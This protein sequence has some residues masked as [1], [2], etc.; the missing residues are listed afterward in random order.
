MPLSFAGSS[1]LTEFDTGAD[2]YAYGVAVTTDV[3]GLNGGLMCTAHPLDDRVRLFGSV[4]GTTVSFGA[5]ETI[6]GP[7]AGE[8]FGS[9]VA[10]SGDYFNAV[11]AVGARD[12]ESDAGR[13]YVYRRTH[14]SDFALEATVTAPTGVTGFGACVDVYY[15]TVL[16]GVME[17][18]SALIVGALSGRAYVYNYNDYSWDDTPEVLTGSFHVDGDITHSVAIRG[19]DS[20]KAMAFYGSA[21][22][23][24]SRGI[25]YQ[26]NRN[27]LGRWD[28]S[29]INVGNSAFDLFGNSCAVA[30]HSQT[31]FAIVIGAPGGNYY[32][33]GH[34][35]GSGPLSLAE[36]AAPQANS[37]YGASVSIA[38]TADNYV[39]AVGAPAEDNNIGAVYVSEYTY[40]DSYGLSTENTE[41]APTDSPASFGSQ[42]AVWGGVGQAV[43]AA[44]AP[45]GTSSRVYAGVATQSEIEVTS[46][47]EWNA[48]STPLT[49][50]VRL[51]SN[52]S[53]AVAPLVKELGAYTLYGDGHTITSTTGI[54]VEFALVSKPVGGMVRDLR[55]TGAHAVTTHSVVVD[56]VNLSIFGHFHQVSVSSGSLADEA[57]GIFGKSFGHRAFPSIVSECSS[58]LDQ[59]AGAVNAGGLI[60]P[61]SV[62]VR[63]T[64][65]AYSG[66]L[67]DGESGGIAATLGINASDQVDLNARSYMQF[68][69]SNQETLTFGSSN[70]MGGLVG[71]LGNGVLNACANYGAVDATVAG[72]LVAE[73]VTDGSSQFAN[74]YMIT[75]CYDAKANGTRPMVGRITGSSDGSAAYLGIRDSYSF[76]QFA[77]G[78]MTEPSVG[79]VS[80]FLSLRVANVHVHN[81]DAIP[82]Y[83]DTQPASVVIDVSSS[84]GAFVITGAGA[85]LTDGG[86]G[87]IDPAFST[88][89]WCKAVSNPPLLR[90]FA[91]ERVGGAATDQIFAG[92]AEGQ[93]PVSLRLVRVANVASESDW[94]SLAWYDVVRL[95][96]NITFTADPSKIVFL[97]KL[98][99]DGRGYTVTHDYADFE[100]FVRLSGG[101]ASNVFIEASG[102]T[103]LTEHGF[104]TPGPGGLVARGAVVNVHAS[105]GAIADDG[106][107]IVGAEFGDSALTSTLRFCTY[108]GVC[109][110]FAGGAITG[111]DPKYLTLESCYAVPSDGGGI[112]TRLV[113]AK[114]NGDAIGTLRVD[115]CF[116]A[117]DHTIS[118]MTFPGMGTS[119][120]IGT[121]RAA[122]GATDVWEV[123]EC[124]V[125][126]RSVTAPG[127]QTHLFG[128]IY[129]GLE[130][131]I[132][133][134]YVRTKG[135]DTN[136]A[137]I[138]ELLDD[139]VNATMQITNVYSNM[140]AADGNAL[141]TGSIDNRTIVVNN[142]H[143]AATDFD[144][145][146]GSTVVGSV[147]DSLDAIGTLELASGLTVDKW[148]PSSAGF[149]RIN[150]GG[151]S[152][153]HYLRH[154]TDP[155]LYTGYTGWDTVPTMLPL[156]AGLQLD[157]LVGY[158]T[159]SAPQFSFNVMLPERVQGRVV[160]SVSVAADWLEVD[161]STQL[162]TWTTDDW[163]EKRAVQLD[164][165]ST[166]AAVSTAVVTVAIDTEL[167]HDPE[168]ASADARTV[169]ISSAAGQMSE[170][171][172]RFGGTGPARGFLLADTGAEAAEAIPDIIDGVGALQ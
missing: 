74:T 140:P 17:P 52:I 115:R 20:G 172:R 78:E 137:A 38:G 134:S 99:F 88:D 18:S 12:A 72:G 110:A 162:L 135:D 92:Y 165:L 22:H 42:V 164:W 83:V 35:T 64:K 80:G 124:F 53:F 46:T 149:V 130:V 19:V 70:V 60:G 111:S 24:S 146:A 44:S 7:T 87:D 85:V 61:Y 86:T 101:T 156:T 29:D 63:L 47:V 26:F 13:V 136:A 59:T 119:G 39:V 1:V 125:A 118:F 108:T 27:A 148:K 113:G 117:V 94:N 62:N 98:E 96:D 154:F 102:N 104:L 82:A 43:L 91:N 51:T 151:S 132:S 168:Y 23:D 45:D 120:L 97:E 3:A 169:R 15:D 55:V 152:T 142:V 73:V 138:A 122:S 95:T 21:T 75:N 69:V 54:G 103:G 5:L 9:A 109:S 6:D 57:G 40:N 170:D 79:E 84:G 76:G 105:S 77:V 126:G 131:A 2:E 14:G 158:L 32:W 50:N 81:T 147:T 16:V 153:Y 161:A 11:L 139:S 116:V 71:R 56:F 121:T 41:C 171:N 155:A 67:S 100:G 163:T 31:D 141:V 33:H 127:P 4:P 8:V 128:G 90:V 123:N 157:R 160:V 106:G 145:G 167:T 68:C 49:G 89:Y 58:S 144:I 25:V 107:G 30:G 159:A 114:T 37:L 93:A 66:T 112:D 36:V 65:C 143:C 48:L 129:G 34:V 166:P 133:D 150:D 28:E 10:L